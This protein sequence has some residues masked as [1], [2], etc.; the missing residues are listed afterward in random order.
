M[1]RSSLLSLG[2]LIFVFCVAIWIFESQTR[3]FQR[4]YDDRVLDNSNHNLSCDQLPVEHEDRQ[5]MQAHPAT[6]EKIIQINPGL[7]GVDVD[8]STCPGR[9]DILF[10]YGTHRDRFLIE[11][12]IGSD[13]FFGVPYRLEN[14]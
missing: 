6:I 8:T 10:W 7:V 1:K 2:L 11:S 14:R 5:V 9:A 12:I 13:T 4:M 3:F